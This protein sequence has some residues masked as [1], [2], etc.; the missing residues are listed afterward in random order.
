MAGKFAFT[1]TTMTANGDG[2]VTISATG[3]TDAQ[4]LTVQLIQGTSVLQSQMVM[5][6]NGSFSVTFT[7]VPAPPPSYNVS[8]VGGP[9]VRVPFP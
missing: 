1:S 4:Q 7:P 5:S 3:N 6:T 2:T 8:I 9:I